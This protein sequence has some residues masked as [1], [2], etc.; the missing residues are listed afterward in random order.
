MVTGDHPLTAKAIARQVGIIHDDTVDDIAK[1]E[2]IDAKDV[3]KSRVRA[4]VVTGAELKEMSEKELDE[5]IKFD[6]IVFART[7]PQQKLIIVESV[8][9]ARHIVA[10]TGDGVNDSPALKKADVGIA[11]GIEGSDVSKEAADLI[12]LDDNFA[13]IVHGVEQGRTIFDNLKKSIAYKLTANVPGPPSSSSPPSPVLCSPSL[14]TELVPFVMYVVADMPLM[15]TTVLILCI[16]IGTDMWPAI[17]LAYERP[18]SDIMERRPRDAKKDKLVTGKL[19]AFAY[20]LIGIVQAVVRFS[21]EPLISTYP[22]PPPP[23]S[24][25]L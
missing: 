3:D 21:F 20:L 12:L 19:I 23:P 13:S 14:P 2:G 10:V 4:I 7:S 8:Q 9:R 18:E 25:S 1:R 5:V 17:A 24:S 16:D 15:L 6:Q 22:R 11:M